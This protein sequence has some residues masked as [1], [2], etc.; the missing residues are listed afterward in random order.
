MCGSRVVSVVKLSGRLLWP[1]MYLL[2]PVRNKGEGAGCHELLSICDVR[3]LG[4][5]LCSVPNLFPVVT[6]N[7][8]LT[9]LELGARTCVCNCG[10][11]KT[12]GSTDGDK[13]Y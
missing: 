3:L 2:T 6:A 8:L 12:R 13:G 7:F 1:L 10:M 4:Y 5:G 11:Q 9:I